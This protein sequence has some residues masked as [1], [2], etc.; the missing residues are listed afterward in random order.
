MGLR[1]YP[2]LFIGGPADGQVIYTDGEGTKWQVP[3][4]V[5]AKPI[6]HH[7]AD[8]VAV[9][10]LEEDYSAEYYYVT[11]LND[12]KRRYCIAVPFK[13]REN[14]IGHLLRSYL[15]KVELAK[16]VPREFKEYWTNQGDD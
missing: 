4:P 7:Y 5:A 14:V 10:D 13:E 12:R 16:F 6:Y 8:E 2:T 9:A 15:E 3:K 11:T 1:E